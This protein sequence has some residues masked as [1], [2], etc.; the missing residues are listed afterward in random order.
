MA[1]SRI[2]PM[3]DAD[4][5]RL[6]EAGMRSEISGEFTR[7]LTSGDVTFT[8]DNLRKLAA[9]LTALFP[10]FDGSFYE[11]LDV[12]R[13]LHRKVP[14]RRLR[15]NN[16]ISFPMLKVDKEGLVPCSNTICV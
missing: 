10:S 5:Y 2:L 15:A 1:K 16:G 13:D 4:Y 12:D 3:T 9:E 7:S 6:R 11:L 8:V 14:K